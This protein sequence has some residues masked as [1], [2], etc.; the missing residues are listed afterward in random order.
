MNSDKVEWPA[1]WFSPRAVEADAWIPTSPDTRC[2]SEL[3]KTKVFEQLRGWADR[4]ERTTPLHKAMLREAADS[5]DAIVKERNELRAE[6]E[7]LQGLLRGTGA[8]RYWEG[9]WRDEA[10]ENERLRAAQGR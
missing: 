5:W 1:L 9:R 7:R 8:N 4:F 6:I 10:K 3:G 2:M